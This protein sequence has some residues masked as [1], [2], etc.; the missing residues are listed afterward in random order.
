MKEWER[1]VNQSKNNLWLV[2]TKSQKLLCAK[3]DGVFFIKSPIKLIV[4]LVYILRV[5]QI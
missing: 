2:T 4:P 5:E 3:I 1:L